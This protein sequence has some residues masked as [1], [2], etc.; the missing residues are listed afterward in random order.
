MRM[1]VDF[2]RTLGAAYRSIC[3]DG[4][5]EPELRTFCK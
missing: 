2:E 4:A 3:S 1:I 5:G